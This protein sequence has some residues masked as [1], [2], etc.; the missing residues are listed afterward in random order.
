MMERFKKIVEE[1]LWEKEIY[2][3]NIEP[4]PPK[5]ELTKV[6]IAIK[7]LIIVIISI[8]MEDGLLNEWW[9]YDD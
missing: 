2:G 5:L 3:S 4:Q 8:L 9:D 1:V 6:E 7:K